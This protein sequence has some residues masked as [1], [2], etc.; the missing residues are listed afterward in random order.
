MDKNSKLS[1]KVFENTE[2]IKLKYKY[3]NKRLKGNRKVLQAKIFS[4]S[5][6]MHNMGYN[7]DVGHL[8]H[9]YNYP[10]A[11]NMVDNEDYVAN[12]YA[13]PHNYSNYEYIS[14]SQRQAP[15]GYLEVEE[16]Q[17]NSPKNTN[18]QNYNNFNRKVDLNEGAYSPIGKRYNFSEFNPRESQTDYHKTRLPQ[19]KPETSLEVVGSPSSKHSMSLYKGGIGQHV[20]SEQKLKMEHPEYKKKSYNVEY[21]TENRHSVANK[22]LEYQILKQ[23]LEDDIKDSPNYAINKRK[24]SVKHRIVN[25][26][27]PSKPM[28]KVHS[29]ENLRKVLSS[30][31]KQ[32]YVADEYQVNREADA[33]TGPNG[34][35]FG[36]VNSHF[37]QLGQIDINEA[38]RSLSPTSSSGKIPKKKKIALPKIF[39]Q[40]F[41]A[42]FAD[43]IGKSI[44][45]KT[46][47]AIGS[48]IT[49][50]PQNIN[51]FYINQL[52]INNKKQ[53]NSIYE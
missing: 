37:N 15:N 6:R 22:N 7:K 53:A 45:S 11:L 9:S 8:E 31:F 5:A 17:F 35:I 12:K 1:H 20:Q 51:L 41:D 48:E 14:N 4:P 13:L 50:G 34:Y 16:L 26:I 23:S 39:I 40:K 21:F 46:L 24:N 44:S 19:I 42:E 28:S 3:D 18:Y 43:K 47:K 27:K 29:Q 49:N 33:Q 38:I 30:N 2:R 25:Q 52:E 10:I 32:N 36:N